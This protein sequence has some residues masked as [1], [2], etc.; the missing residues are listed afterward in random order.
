MDARF[1]R[2]EMLVGADGFSKLKS[3]FVVIAGLGGVGSFSLEALA[4]SGIGKIRVIDC[5]IV[6]PSNINRQIIATEPVLGKLK[7]EVAAQRIREINPNCKVE[8][9]NMFIDSTTSF[10]SIEGNPDAVIDAIDSLNP[11]IEFLKACQKQKLFVVS[12][13]G[14][15]RRMDP[16]KVKIGFLTNVNSCPLASKI[17][18]R[19]R[20]RELSVDILCAYSEEPV[21]S[22]K[23]DENQIIE[24]PTLY[25]RG[26]KRNPM[27]SLPTVVGMFGLLIAHAV[28]EKI[29][30]NRIETPN[31]NS[32]NFS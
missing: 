6:V 20:Q 7:S 15:A 18:K 3:S 22:L 29:L 23:I 21:H 28:I 2:I 25:K 32:L 30:K 12:S 10:Q 11:K 8:A 27:G 4:R 13:M 16:T 17:R 31:T 1:S 19:L 24:E 26:R 5:D 14:A 9:Y